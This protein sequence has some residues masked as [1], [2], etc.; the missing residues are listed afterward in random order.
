MNADEVMR[1]FSKD[2]II[3]ALFEMECEKLEINPEG[4]LLLFQIEFV[5]ICR[6]DERQKKSGRLN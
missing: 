5:K 3:K 6:E 1:E 4:L 2:E